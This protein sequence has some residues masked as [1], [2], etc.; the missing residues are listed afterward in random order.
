MPSWPWDPHAVREKDAETG[1]E[2]GEEGGLPPSGSQA[3][4]FLPKPGCAHGSGGRPGPL[5]VTS[6]L[7]AAPVSVPY[8]G[9]PPG[10]PSGHMNSLAHLTAWFLQTRTVCAP[11]SCW[12]SF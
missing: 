2:P 9:A 10:S 8:L 12:T 11:A 6:F 3:R 4:P 5:A 7:P 1:P